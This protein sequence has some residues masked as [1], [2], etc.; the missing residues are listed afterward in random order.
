MIILCVLCLIISRVPRSLAKLVKLDAFPVLPG[1]GPNQPGHT[2]PAGDT[3][4][5]AVE[6][7]AAL[8][9]SDAFGML[10]VCKLD[11]SPSINAS[12]LSV[13]LD[14]APVL[15]SHD[16]ANPW[17]QLWTHVRYSASRPFG[18][19]ASL[20]SC[21]ALSQQCGCDTDELGV[22]GDPVA[23]T[24]DAVV[25]SKQLCGGLQGQVAR[26][27]QSR[28]CSPSLPVKPQQFGADLEVRMPSLRA[29]ANALG[30][31][32]VDPPLSRLY[33]SRVLLPAAALAALSLEAVQ[34]GAPLER[35]I[36]A[37]APFDTTP[38]SGLLK[39]SAMPT[40]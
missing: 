32:V 10:V 1:P 6:R 29:T 37:F 21:V 18:Q 16:G 7:A 17:V 35:R 5:F 11:D 8:S 23:L 19:E 25:P 15:V 31:G 14:G 39:G 4:H 22:C 36:L 13:C 3:F 33:A 12:A 2:G 20:A 40:R 9:R 27:L 26:A 34:Y 28:H 38:L 24:H 30:D